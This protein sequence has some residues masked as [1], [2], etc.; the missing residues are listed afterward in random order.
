[1][2]AAH[3]EILT[4]K[5]CDKLFRSRRAITGHKA[6]V[7]GM[8]KGNQ[9]PNSNDESDEFGVNDSTSEPIPKKRKLKIKEIECKYCGR[10]YS[11]QLFHDKHVIEHGKYLF[12]DAMKN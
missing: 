12:T 7:H 9:N 4:C 2:I 5:I 3:E 11:N 1:M 6:S 10:G 8:K